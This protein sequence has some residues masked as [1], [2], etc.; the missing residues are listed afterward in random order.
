MLYGKNLT[1]LLV[2]GQELMNAPLASSLIA[3][4]GAEKPRPEKLWPSLPCFPAEQRTQ[5]RNSSFKGEF[6]AHNSCMNIRKTSI[7]CL[8]TFLKWYF[9]Y[10]D[11]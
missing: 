11:T 10:N 9:W 7:S 6:I 8:L 4:L 1:G 5:N 2:T 3:A